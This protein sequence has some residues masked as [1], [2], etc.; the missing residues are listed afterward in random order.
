MMLWILLTSSILVTCLEP[1]RESTL[2][3]MIEHWCCSPSPAGADAFGCR[4]RRAYGV[5][6]ASLLSASAVELHRTRRTSSGDDVH[7]RAGG[8]CSVSQYKR[9]GRRA[10]TSTKKEVRARHLDCVARG[11][12]GAVVTPS[13]NASDLTKEMLRQWI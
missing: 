2:A 5:L 9:N 10:K 11:P 12:V 13:I 6:V 7:S 8:T 4:S 1:C 3:W